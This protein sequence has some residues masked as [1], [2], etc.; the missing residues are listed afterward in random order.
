MARRKIN[1]DEKVQLEMTPMIDVVFQLLIFFLV[2][3]KPIAQIGELDV[4]RPAPDPNARP[5]DKVEDMI[6]ITVLQNNRY[7]LNARSMTLQT[8]EEN[9]QR[10]AAKSKTQTVL[11]ECAESS[12]HGSLV[13][14]LDLCAKV[15]L[16]NLSVITM[17][18]GKGPV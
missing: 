10:A 14:V 7:L 2:T 17:S 9:L 16:V 3:L 8:I 12:R 11:V 18:T 4:F 1:S 5:E 6:R 13:S 15:H